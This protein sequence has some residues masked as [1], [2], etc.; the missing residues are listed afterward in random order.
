MK[1]SEYD[2]LLR[3]ALLDAERA[4][5]AQALEGAPPEP[6]FSPGYRRRRMKLLNAP[7][8]YG[9]RRAR[10]L[11]RRALQTAA[12]LL[13]TAAVTLGGV[14]AVS[15]AVRAWVLRVVM[16][17]DDTV[18]T[19]RFGGSTDEQVNGAQWT[20][21]YV[22]DGYEVVDVWERNRSV[23]ITY[24]NEKGE[25]IDYSC[26]PLEDGFAFDVDNEHSDLHEITVNGLKATLMISN[27]EGYNNYLLWTNEEQG[28]A[29]L[30]IS[31]IDSREMVRMAESVYYIG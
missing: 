29:H 5:W 14:M 30:I 28:T 19:F 1:A 17:W 20:P 4:D 2:E 21:S 15:P 24:E 23:T 26:T 31:K 27:T 10:P 13:L 18:A 25:W 12:C 7:F 8:A 22:P 6:E 9:K 16:E 11:W 3:A